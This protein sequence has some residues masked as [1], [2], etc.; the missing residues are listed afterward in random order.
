MC[1]RCLINKYLVVWGWPGLGW[2]SSKFNVKKRFIILRAY[3]NFS[4]MFYNDFMP[5]KFK[6]ALSVCEKQKLSIYKMS[7]E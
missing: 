2:L 3:F 5:I 7:F 6:Q 1:S 4:E